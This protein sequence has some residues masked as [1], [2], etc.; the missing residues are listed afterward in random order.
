MTAAPAGT[1]SPAVADAAGDGRLLH[2]FAVVLAIW[3]FGL[4]SAGGVVTGKEAGLAVPDW[5]LSYGHVNPPGWTVPDNVFVEHLHRLLGWAAGAMTIALALWIQSRDPR[6]WMRRL[7]WVVLGAIVVQGVIGGYFRVVLLQHGM[8]VVHGITGQAFFCLVTA[9][10]LFLSPGWR[11]A[12]PAAEDPSARR[13]HR[14]TLCAAVALFL[15]VVIGA[16]VRHSRL[17][18]SIAHVAPHALWGVVAAGLS[19]AALSEALRAR[20]ARGALLAPALVLGGG[21]AL[22]VLLGLGAYFANTVGVQEIVRPTMQVVATSIHQA[23]GAAVLAASVV[24]H[25]RTRRLL[26]EPSPEAAPAT[27]GLAAAGAAS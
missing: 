5:P 25:L 6:P 15:Q 4:L 13:L 9:T 7:G 26:R 3:T 12:P 16:L 11:D 8:A 18:H 1:R 19:L 20:A 2:A 23:A 24:L 21:A 17:G 14:L 10:A 22:Q 27:R